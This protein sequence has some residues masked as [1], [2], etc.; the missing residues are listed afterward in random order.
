MTTWAP[1]Q[2]ESESTRQADEAG[3]GREPHDHP[4]RPCC[5][6]ISTMG[7][8]DVH[9]AVQPGSHRQEEASP[10]SGCKGP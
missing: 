5:W 6:A 7:K 1:E 4:V 9:Q 8:T 3:W 2:K 10:H